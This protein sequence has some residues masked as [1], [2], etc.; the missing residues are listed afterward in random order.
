MCEKRS[1]DGN[2]G[3]NDENR[4][5]DHIEDLRRMAKQLWP[6]SFAFDFIEARGAKTTLPSTQR[7]KALPTTGCNHAS[8]WM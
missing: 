8:S 6:Q 4:P 1:N 3:G 2:G 5:C 7:K